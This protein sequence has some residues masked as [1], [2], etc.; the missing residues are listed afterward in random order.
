ME[1]EMKQHKL[2]TI[3]G[4]FGENYLTWSSKSPRGPDPSKLQI[5]LLKMVIKEGFWSNQTRDNTNCKVRKKDGNLEDL[6]E[7]FPLS[8]VVND[9][10]KLVDSDFVA[11]VDPVVELWNH[12]QARVSERADFVVEGRL[13]GP[14][15]VGP[16]IILGTIIIAHIK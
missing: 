16:A 6:G 13:L 9:A 1:N 5:G 12:I 4:K 15:R 8:D 3:W 7:A 11:I 10:L 2:N 14:A